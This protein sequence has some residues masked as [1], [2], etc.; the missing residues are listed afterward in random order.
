M[1]L[2]C[3]ALHTGNASGLC[4]RLYVSNTKLTP[5]GSHV[6]LFFIRSIPDFTDA[7]L[8]AKKAHLGF[9]NL[10]RTLVNEEEGKT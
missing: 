1:K 4:A 10:G 6:P 5:S 9:L 8:K 2:V 7:I 3:Y